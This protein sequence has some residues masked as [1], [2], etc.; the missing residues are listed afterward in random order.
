MSDSFTLYS[1]STTPQNSS[2]Y[3]LGFG[4]NRTIGNEVT[5]SARFFGGGCHTKV[6]HLFVFFCPGK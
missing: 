3:E 4:S 6:N 5:H 2:I 1:S